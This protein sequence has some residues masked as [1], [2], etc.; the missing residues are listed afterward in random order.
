MRRSSPSSEGPGS[1]RT[2]ASL[3]PVALIGVF[4]PPVGGQA[5]FNER[6]AEE[7]RRRG[8]DVRRVDVGPS[9]GSP[10]AR[11]AQVLLR[12]EFSLFHL[13]ASDTRVLG[14][15]P[16]VA[17][18]SLLRRVPFVSHVLAGRFG[19]RASS[20]AWPHR[21]LLCASLSRATCLLVSNEAMATEVRRLP[22]LGKKEVHVV[23]CR[24]P[25]DVRPEEDPSLGEFLAG[26]DPSIVAVGAM[27][28]VY[29][30][31]LLTQAC[32]LLAA[33]GMHP[34]LLLIV[35]GSAEPYPS[36]REALRG[37]WPLLVKSD[38]PRP[39]VLGAMRRASVVVR[40]TRADG[41]S[42]SVHEAMALGV[43]VV[44]SDVVPRPAGVVLYRTDDPVALAEAIGRALSVGAPPAPTEETPLV[45][46]ILS[47][48]RAAWER[49]R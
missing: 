35:A 12:G 5:I 18:A 41:D 4:P 39:V 7:L 11:L 25:L 44:A 21:V 34:R 46:R 17:A 14:F 38:L 26:G 1:G 10:R 48:Y 16:I 15:E 20:Y 23:G 32:T 28:P 2:H 29:G 47:C 49:P 6:L 42:L 22:L 9:G 19:Q 40:P 36:L 27:R 33:R 13:T 45:D 30:F 8:V 24:L 3:G 31:D 37:E 43:P